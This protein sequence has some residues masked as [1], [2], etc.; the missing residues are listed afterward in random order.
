MSEHISESNVYRID[1]YKRRWLANVVKRSFNQKFSI[2]I[3][4]R[5]V[6]LDLHVTLVSVLRHVIGCLK[7]Q[8]LFVERHNRSLRNILSF[9]GIGRRLDAIL[10]FPLANLFVS[11]LRAT[12]IETIRK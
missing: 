5:V 6:L 10:F 8:R 12:F 11:R 4:Y 9:D 2:K 1:E 7:Q 3:L